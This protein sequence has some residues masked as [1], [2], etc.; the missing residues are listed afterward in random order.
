MLHTGKDNKN[1]KNSIITFLK[2]G[3]KKYNQYLKNKEIVWKK[4]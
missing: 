3:K 2:V 1:Y 4:D